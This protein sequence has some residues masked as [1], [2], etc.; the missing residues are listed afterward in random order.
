MSTNYVSKTFGMIF[1]IVLVM[2]TDVPPLL[3]WLL[4]RCWSLLDAGA[5]IPCSMLACSPPRLPSPRRCVPFQTR[6]EHAVVPG[7][8]FAASENFLR[9]LTSVKTSNSYCKFFQYFFRSSTDFQCTWLG[10]PL[11]PPVGPSS[12]ALCV[13]P[14][15]A[16]VGVTRQINGCVK[17][18]E[19]PHKQQSTRKG[20]PRAPDRQQSFRWGLCMW[21]LVGGTHTSIL[22]PYQMRIFLSFLLHLLWRTLR[23]EN[24]ME[25]GRPD[26]RSICLYRWDWLLHVCG[27][28]GVWTRA[29]CFLTCYRGSG[30]KDK[31]VPGGWICPCPLP[32]IAHMHKRN[33]SKHLLGDGKEQRQRNVFASRIWQ[34]TNCS[35]KSD[36]TR[37]PTSPV[38]LSW[39]PSL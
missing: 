16:P 36:L 28:E 26:G 39:I 11:V 32:T 31:R 4:T 22:T 10:F 17:T 27:F 18:E 9:V 2:S 12:L 34:E 8:F 30:R 7:I 25:L 13:F 24:A 1:L 38:R 21:M 23:F 20:S 3:R 35:G 15:G 19:Y 33:R 5:W 37:R 6:L 29:G 14:R